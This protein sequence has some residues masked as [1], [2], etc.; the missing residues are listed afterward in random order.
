MSFLSAG[1][2]LTGLFSRD[3]QRSHLSSV[4]WPCERRKPEILFLLFRMSIRTEPSALIPVEWLV[5]LLQYW[6]VAKCFHTRNIN[7]WGSFGTIKLTREITSQALMGIQEYTGGLDKMMGRPTMTQSA[8]FADVVWFDFHMES[9]IK[10]KMEWIIKK[11][12]TSNRIKRE[13]KWTAEKLPL[14]WP[15]SSWSDIQPSRTRAVR[16]TTRTRVQVT[17]FKKLS[18]VLSSFFFVYPTA[19]ALQRRKG[20]EC[21]MFPLSLAVLFQ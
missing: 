16:W 6:S 17:N 18:T 7:C 20:E 11:N 1:A 12:E 13:V 4:P 10:C 15:W 21:V 14:T 19:N 8:S 3:K 5:S 9:V 2:W